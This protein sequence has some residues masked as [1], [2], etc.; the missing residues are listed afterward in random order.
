MRMQPV[1]GNEA[2]FLLLAICC[3]TARRTHFGADA[4]VNKFL[5]QLHLDVH[6]LTVFF[7]AFLC[8]VL[9]YSEADALSALDAALPI[10]CPAA[11]LEALKSHVSRGLPPAQ[12]QV[13][14]TVQSVFHPVCEVP[15]FLRCQESIFSPRSACV[16]GAA[17][18]AAS[19]PQ[20]LQMPDMFD[21]E[22][23]RKHAARGDL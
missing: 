19:R 11:T 18:E 12:L 2:C 20:G 13:E 21:N 8:R 15:H 14:N 22:S 5:M 6:F 3:R 10:C 9:S 23:D 16:A 1:S 17:A 7:F 4:L